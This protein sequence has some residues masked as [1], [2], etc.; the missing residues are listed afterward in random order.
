MTLH[1]GDCCE[2]LPTFPEGGFDSAVTDPP[3]ELGFMGRKWDSSGVAFDPATWSEVLRVV[4]PGGYMLCFGGTRTYHRLA[5]AVED[6]GF[7]IRDCLMWVYGTG[8]PKGQG[9][10]KPAWE[11]ILLARKPGPRVLPLGIDACRAGTEVETWPKS[12]GYSRHDTG[13]PVKVAAQPT[14]DPPPG[15]WP[16]NVLHDGSDEVLEAFA[17]FGER[18]GTTSGGPAERNSGRSEDYWGEG[19]GG[20]ATVGRSTVFHNDTGTAA[21]FFYCAKASKS[22]RG[23]GNT[24]PTVK[25]LALMR[26]LVRLVTPPGG[27]VLDP[28][29]GSG[30]T[31]L[32]AREEGMS[33]VG[34]EQD[35]GHCDIIRNRLAAGADNPN[36]FSDVA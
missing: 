33:A 17:A 26:W 34:I 8:F 2:V 21:R 31:L 1:E 3:Y 12:R 23:D 15:R 30:T 6:A 32:A 5:C 22:E 9:C 13:N 27:S 29:A 20:F 7:K 28:F 35:T 25:P 36:L 10:L 24:H 14:G 16:A 19:G 18:G 4:K 11:P